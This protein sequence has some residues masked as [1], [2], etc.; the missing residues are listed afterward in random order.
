MTEKGEGRSSQVVSK[1][2]G[3]GHPSMITDIGSKVFQV[4]KVIVDTLSR[5][6]LAV[7]ASQIQHHLG[8]TL[9][10]KVLRT[11]GG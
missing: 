2:P 3:A 4:K 9:S 5:S 10:S 11:L 6:Y 7:T 1:T 8:S